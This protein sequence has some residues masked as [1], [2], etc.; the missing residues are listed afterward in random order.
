M[1]QRGRLLEFRPPFAQVQI[2]FE[3]RLQPGR[4]C[5]LNR[6]VA[7]QSS[8]CCLNA[9]AQRGQFSVFEHVSSERTQESR[10]FKMAQEIDEI[11]SALA[12]QNDVTAVSGK[13][14]ASKQSSPAVGF[15]VR[16]LK[17]FATWFGRLKVR[18]LPSREWDAIP[19]VKNF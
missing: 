11:G 8:H 6:F 18:I 13:G 12:R 5:N 4:V 10:Q 16:R 7:E 1:G 3:T 14:H 2:L 17:W 9:H 19:H 15:Q